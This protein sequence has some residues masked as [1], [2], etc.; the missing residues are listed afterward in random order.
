VSLLAEIPIQEAADVE[1]QVAL[2]VDAMRRR[3]VSYF[4]AIEDARSL[5]MD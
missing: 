3:C 2:A 4:N 5:T 1:E